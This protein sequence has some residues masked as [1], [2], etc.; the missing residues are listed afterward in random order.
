[1]SII[2]GDNNSNTLKGTNNLDI[3]VGNNG[4][5]TINGGGGDDLI[6][7]GNG[8][9][10]ISG[11]GGNDL[12]SGDNGDDIINAGTGSDIVFG[13]NGSDTIDG[14]SGSDIILGGNGND[15]LIYRASENVGVTDCYDGDNGSDTLRL[16]VTQALANSA[17]FQADISALQ[18]MLALGSASYDFKSI[19]LNVV[20]IEKLQI[21]VEGGTSNHAPVAVADAVNA[22]E[23]IS[24]TI[25]A[26]SLLANDTDADSGD[27]KTLV[28]VQGAQHGT[29]SINSS[30]NIVFVAEANFSGVANF[31]YTMKDAAGATSTATVTVNVAA[32]A[33]APTLT[34]APAS[35]DED[36]AITLSIATA[37]TDLDG[38][39]QLESLVVDNIPV[40]ATLS[41]GSHSFTAGATTSVDIKGWTLSSLKITPPANSDADFSL[42]V[43]ATSQEGAGGPTASSTAYLVVTVNPIAD[44]PTLTIAPASGNEDTAITLSIATALTDLDGSEQ[45][46]SLVVGNIPVGATLSDGSHSFTA[47]AGTSSVDIEGWTLSSLKITPPA[48]SDADFSLTVTATSQEGAGGPTASSTAYL[49]VTVNPVADAP[50]VAVQPVSTTAS[51]DDIPLFIDVALSDP[52]EALS[53]VKID[54]LPSAYVLNHG[55]LAGDGSWLVAASDLGDLAMR[56]AGGGVGLAG[57]FA[58]T[59]TATSVDGTSTASNQAA[60]LVEVAPPA[61]AL[62]GLVQDGYVAGAT[63]FSDL[64][65][66]GI[67]DAGEVFTT[68]AA[69]GTFTLATSLPGLHSTAR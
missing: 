59:V 66:N 42:T 36:T 22:T 39:E 6:S 13:G 31:T 37:L 45:L 11:G 65:D 15:T 3:I 35:G 10:T 7:G 63:V 27:T 61:N 67:L 8:N 28:S 41:D 58:L 4:N 62:S 5:D 38:S 60:L 46:E 56:P 1:M 69:D 17:A 33:D 32:V 16:I 47:V 44:A 12:I 54:G 24:L 25:L 18:A 49:A 64:N 55:L 14:G 52:S 19:D 34:V 29:V 43:T 51:A 48:N 68:T 30:G 2:I 9:D 23:D 26:S 57:N 50:T 53:T 21:V 20:S 40:G